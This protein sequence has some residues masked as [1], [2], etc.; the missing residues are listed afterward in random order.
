MYIMFSAL[1]TTAKVW[2]QPTCPSTDDWVDEMGSSHPMEY[3]SASERKG[4]LTHSRTW[5]DLEDIV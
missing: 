3:Y 5:M 1:F 4:V 2:K